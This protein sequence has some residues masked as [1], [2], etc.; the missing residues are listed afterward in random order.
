VT[1][2][3]DSSPERPF[4][5]ASIGVGKKGMIKFWAKKDALSWM[6]LVKGHKKA[7]GKMP[8]RGE[9][10]RLVQPI[11]DAVKGMAEGD[12]S[13]SE[14][15]N[16][17]SEDR[18]IAKLKRVKTKK[19]RMRLLGLTVIMLEI[20]TEIGSDEAV[21]SMGAKIKMALMKGIKTHLGTG[22]K[23]T[24]EEYDLDA[25]FEAIIENPDEE[26]M[27]ANAGASLPMPF[28]ATVS[29]SGFD[30]RPKQ[31][32]KDDEDE[33]ED[34]YEDND[35]PKGF[36]ANQKK[37]RDA[38]GDGKTNEPD[39]RDDDDDDDDMDEAF[40]GRSMKISVADV[41]K[42]AKRYKMSV[43]VHGV[44]G[45]GIGLQGKDAEKL[46]GA[47]T[48]KGLKR[49]ADRKDGVIVLHE[50]GDDDIEESVQLPSEE[51]GG[52]PG[53][54]EDFKAGYK[55]GAAAYAKDDSVS[56]VDGSKAYRKVSRK[57]G[58]W[59]KEGYSAAVDMA[60]GANRTSGAKIAKKL[61]LEGL[62]ED[63]L[64]ESG[65]FAGKGWTMQAKWLKL[66]AK[67]EPAKF[68]Q[69][70]AKEIVAEA[71]AKSR[72]GA[73]SDQL[74]RVMTQGEHKYILTVWDGMSGNTSFVDA[75]MKVAKGKA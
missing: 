59:W 32:G 18:W 19:G 73:W 61:R 30:G 46:A 17:S 58:I 37:G 22:K 69:D 34:V 3:S 9:I 42:A 49:G 57:H 44:A 23:E 21:K 11:K 51:K 65:P 50:D 53:Y 68:D 75:L 56:G 8:Y 47:L 27:A 71:K 39:P 20:L 5:I 14:K 66:A 38:D 43:K 45:G 1:V 74:S 4:S 41:K 62:D 31:N 7:E 26:T 16:E 40:S 52:K 25:V 24:E 6:L 15:M 33:D 29:R 13:L 10:G 28:R 72:Y 60:R 35:L 70:R 36:K 55:A 2:H 67:A 63:T 48:K 12:E 54:D 64:E